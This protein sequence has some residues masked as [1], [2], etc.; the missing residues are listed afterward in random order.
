MNN[1]TEIFNTKQSIWLDFISRDMI[2]D[3]RIENFVKNK[4]IFG[5]TSNPAIFN[6]AIS[7]SSMYDDFIYKAVKDGCSSVDSMYENVVVRDIKDA[8]DLLIGVYEN[9]LK[10]DGYVSLEVSPFLAFDADNTIREAKRLWKVVNKPNLMIKVP[11]TNEGIV[12]F[13]R[14]ISDGINVNVTLI[15][16][17]EQY[18][19]VL[20]SY[21]SGLEDRLLAGKSIN[22]IFSVAS[23]FISRMDSFLDN[24]LPD[25]LRGCVGIANATRAFNY[26]KLITLSDKRFR[27]LLDGGANIQKLL[28]AST[29]VKNS[30]YPE[31]MYIDRLI[32]PNTINTVPLL[33]FN[34]IRG[35]E[36][37]RELLNLDDYVA[38]FRELINSRISIRNAGDQLLLR[39][40]SLFCGSFNEMLNTISR[41]MQQ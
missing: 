18:R 32:F 19:K 21:I 17:L 12:A 10:K 39:G 25:D 31:T 27:R 22:N 24:L 20:C 8:A 33:T 15:F 37:N 29:S 34:L 26:F 16:S 14:L 36:I 41:K 4:E 28:W 2:F 38:V 7:N 6:D 13:R 11:A 3:G 40:L 30:N 5:L 9:T 23:F 35:R 1:Y